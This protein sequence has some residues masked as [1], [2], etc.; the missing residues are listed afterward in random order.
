MLVAYAASALEKLPQ[1]G[2]AA[3]AD[4]LQSV[5]GALLKNLDAAQQGGLVA[6]GP[7]DI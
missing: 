4:L 6:R 2:H 7:P 5:G 3:M 1:G